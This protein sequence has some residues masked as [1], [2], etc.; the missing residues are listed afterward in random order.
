[1]TNYTI[2]FHNKVGLFTPMLQM[3]KW[4][5]REVKELALASCLVNDR[6]EI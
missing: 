3:R 5:L 4:S 2:R 1:M 6:V